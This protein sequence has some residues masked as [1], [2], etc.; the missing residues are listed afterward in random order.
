[1][2]FDFIHD[3]QFKIILERD[4]EELQNCLRANASKASLL[5]CGSI[6]EA[7][8]TDYFL[9][10]PP[11]GV[12]RTN[13]LKSNLNALLGF[14]ENSGLIN[15]KDKH[16]GVIIKDYRNLIHPGK[17]VRTGEEFDFETAELAKILLDIILRKLRNAHLEQFGTTSEEVLKK[18][19][20]DWDYN[21]IFG[22]VVTKLSHNER[23]KLLEELVQIEE[24]YKTDLMQSSFD[25]DPRISAKLG[26]L[27][28]LE[29]I[30]D[31][32]QAI[33]PLVRDDILEGYLEQLKTSVLT[34][35]RARA[36]A[37]YNLFHEELNQLTPEDQ[38]LIAIYILSMYESIFE[39]S[40]TLAYEKT[41]STIGKYIHSQKGVD[42]L[43]TLARFC[44]VHFYGD[45]TRQ[46]DVFEQILNS[47]S[48][49]VQTEI[50]NDLQAFFP[51]TRSK[52]ESFSLQYFYDE[53][54]NRNMIEEKYGN[55][56]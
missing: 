4:Y 43:K 28:N 10:N 11:Q 13:I 50:I 18:L 14:A 17:E 15:S 53:A 21:S 48:T 36:L 35:E 37:L 3:R 47:T 41:Y 1:M 30:K 8:L 29:D 16:L 12:S 40:R 6:I 26:A 7:V 5:I 52:L 49:S 54:L 31:K 34:G 24:L 20:N 27:E 42:R 38:E 19:K 32:V 39:S 45:A 33:K 25:P 46:M 56:S 2:E 44:V 51:E 55:G 23:E 22:L 9:E